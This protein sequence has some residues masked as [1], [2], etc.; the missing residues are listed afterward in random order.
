[1][2]TNCKSWG[3]LGTIIF[4][5]VSLAGAQQQDAEARRFFLLGLREKDAQKKIAAYNQ[6]LSL[7]SEFVEALFNIGL[8]YRQELDY[9][10]AEQFLLRALHARPERTSVGTKTQILYELGRIAARL[11][12]TAENE[13]YLRGAKALAAEPEVRAT[14]IWELCNTLKIQGRYAEALGEAREG[15]TLHSERASAF[16][17][18]TS[19]LENEI[20]AQRAGTGPSTGTSAA[21]LVPAQK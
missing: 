9:M 11:G 19:Q 10:R 7:D 16:G 4:C 6:A 13:T 20:P 8:A 18:L 21:S 1:M 3:W 15:Q 2:N 5:S 14:I 17:T 12:K